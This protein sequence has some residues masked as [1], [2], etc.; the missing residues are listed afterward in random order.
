MLYQVWS[1]AETRPNTADQ[2]QS[3]H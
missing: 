2:D 1:I 3:D